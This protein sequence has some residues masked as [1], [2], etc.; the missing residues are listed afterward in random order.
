[1][2]WTSLSLF[3]VLTQAAAGLVFFYG[4]LGLYGRPAPARESAGYHQLGG[5]VLLAAGLTSGIGM[6]ISLAHLGWPQFAFRALGGLPTSWLSWEVL[7]IGLF[8]LAALGLWWRHRQGSGALPPLALGL[9]ALLGLGATCASGMVYTFPALPANAGGF[10]VIF[11]LATALVTGAGALMLLLV[12]TE[13]G[14][15]L[16]PGWMPALLTL[17]AVLLLLG[18]GLTL[19]YAWT[20]AAGVPEAR[21]QAALLTGS[22]WFGVRLIFGLLTPAVL[23]LWAARQP[24][25]SRAVVVLPVLLVAAGEVAGRLLFFASS[26]FTGINTGL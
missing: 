10:P 3:T 21:V 16:A 5:H 22:P 1:M 23:C 24:R 9:L 19:T 20:A 6:L 11:F 13:P 18:A 12:L 15:E 17:T 26:V 25:L 2:E 7:L 8:T 4:L 14:R